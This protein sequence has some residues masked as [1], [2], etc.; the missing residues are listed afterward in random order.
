MAPTAY[1]ESISYDKDGDDLVVRSGVSEWN[2]LFRVPGDFD[3]SDPPK[4]F[5]LKLDA[6]REGEG[7]M[8]V[9]LRVQKLSDEDVKAGLD[10]LVKRQ[11]SGYKA[12]IAEA[13]EP[14]TS[15]RGLNR[16]VEIIGANPSRRLAVVLTRDGNRLYELFLGQTPAGTA[17]DAELTKIGDGFTILEPTEQ[18]APPQHDAPTEAEAKPRKVTHDYWRVTVLKPQGFTLENTEGVEPNLVF[19]FRRKDPNGNLAY[20]RV[21]VRL[22]KATRPVLSTF[23]DKA[24]ETFATKHDDARVPKKP[25]RYGFPGAKEG[26]RLKMLG[27]KRGV[28]VRVDHRFL[29][30]QN[31]RMYEFEVI[32][33]AGADREWKK[34]IRSFWKSI[35]LK[36]K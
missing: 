5:L 1:A 11:V 3:K 21:R 34:E 12:G 19:W 27:M 16:R 33:Y 10:V 15:G 29:D 32:T 17:L 35:R 25:R 36:I 20:I 31:G 14:S 8:Q 24:L 28:P 26:Y 30:H 2:F 18:A 7:E 22:A 6:D 4:G 13:G 23:A 9:L